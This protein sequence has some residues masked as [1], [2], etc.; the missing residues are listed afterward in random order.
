[1]T[2]DERHYPGDVSGASE[3]PQPRAR[4][5][6]RAFT[7]PLTI[8][9]A[10]E[11]LDGLALL[12]FAVFLGVDSVTGDPVQGATSAAVLTATTAVIGL[13]VAVVCVGLARRR[14]WSRSPAVLTQI[15]ALPVAYSLVRGDGGAVGIPL[16]ATALLALG[17]LVNPATSR[18]LLREGIADKPAQ[19]DT[20]GTQQRS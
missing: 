4:S 3:S 18:V 16:G 17:L 19:S 2:G 5:L 1:M 9:T 8:A 10:I 6:G 13:G 11:G 20:G 12:V 15:L 7:Q 14:R